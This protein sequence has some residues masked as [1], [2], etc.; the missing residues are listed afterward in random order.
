[1]GSL[2]DA[3]MARLGAMPGA[4]AS[5]APAPGGRPP[6]AMIYKVMG[7]MFAIVGLGKVQHVILKCDPHLVEVL[8][9][10][11]AGVGRRSHLDPRSWISVELDSD[12]PEEE[13]GRLAEQSYA[14]VCAGLTRKQRAALRT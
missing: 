7:K 10:T 8:K 6:P 11:Y 12:V 13:V 14:L 5:A 1:M 2:R 3:L 9:E 4:M